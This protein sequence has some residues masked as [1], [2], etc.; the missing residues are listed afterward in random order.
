MKEGRKELRETVRREWELD[1]LLYVRVRTRQ[2]PDQSVL[3][4]R[5]RIG[6][7]WKQS[8]CYKLAT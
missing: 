7:Q 5:G 3:Y 8:A 4:V 6:G 1:G 2:V